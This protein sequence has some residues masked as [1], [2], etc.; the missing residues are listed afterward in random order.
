MKAW[1][2]C[3]DQ[4]KKHVSVEIKIVPLTL[5]RERERE[6]EEKE[7]RSQRMLPAFVAQQS[8]GKKVVI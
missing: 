1:H 3:L 6:R 7:K 5:Q 4:K 8:G 2:A